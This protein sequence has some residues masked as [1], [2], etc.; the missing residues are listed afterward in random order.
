MP[1]IIKITVKNSQNNLKHKELSYDLDELYENPYLKKLVD[2][3]IKDFND[4]VEGVRMTI[5]LDFEENNEKEH[6]SIISEV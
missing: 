1:C 2:H 6:N 3:A 5:T 4:E